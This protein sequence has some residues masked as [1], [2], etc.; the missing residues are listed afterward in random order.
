MLAWPNPK[1]FNLQPF[2]IQ[3][4]SNTKKDFFFLTFKVQLKQ[5]WPTCAGGPSQE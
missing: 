3:K 1:C 2:E 5:T 4:C